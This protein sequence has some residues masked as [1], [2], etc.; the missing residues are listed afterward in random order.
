MILGS[1][2]LACSDR[3]DEVNDVIERNLFIDFEFDGVEY[4]FSIQSDTVFF[5]RDFFDPYFSIFM[6][7]NVAQLDSLACEE[8]NGELM[9][10]GGCFFSLSRQWWLLERGFR[11]ESD[12]ITM[13]TYF[14]NALDKKPTSEDLEHLITEGKYIS[15]GYPP[16]NMND[17]YINKRAYTF[18]IRIKDGDI[19]NI[20]SCYNTTWT[21]SPSIKS[22]NGEWSAAQRSDGYFK[23][24][25]IENYSDWPNHFV[26]EY[27]FL[28][29]LSGTLNPLYIEKKVLKGH[30][31]I[32]IRR[33]PFDPGQYDRLSQGFVY[34]GK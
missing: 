1:C 11:V 8:F 13:Q 34:I 3:D 27:E 19:T 2:V 17:T 16:F 18:Y 24:L 29:T 33:L 25:N 7:G 5:P 31:R 26:I 14:R 21:E 12:D 32:P 22:Y 23:V 10:D 30:A 4:N 20:D 9:K 28:D 15:N 6:D